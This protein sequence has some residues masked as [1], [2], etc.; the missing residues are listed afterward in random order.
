MKTSMRREEDIQ[1]VLV[2]ADV[3]HDVVH[4]ILPHIM[5]LQLTCLASISSLSISSLQVSPSGIV[6]YSIDSASITFRSSTDPL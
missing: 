6:W 4:I 1:L 5:Y 3:V 2:S